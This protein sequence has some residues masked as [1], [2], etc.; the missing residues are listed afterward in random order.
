MADASTERTDIVRLLDLYA[1]AL[2]SR[3][4]VLLRE[5]F[6]A[7]A[8]VNFGEGPTREVGEVIDTIRGFLDGCGPTQHLQGNYR[9]DIDG[10]RATSRCYIRAFHLGVDRHTGTTYEMAGE[11]IDALVRTADGWRISERSFSIFWE[12]GNRELLG[13][14]SEG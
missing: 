14:G 4:W 2:D 6:T 1:T 10:D 7:N 13:S 5:V 8:A 11:Y 12:Q 9:V 3:E